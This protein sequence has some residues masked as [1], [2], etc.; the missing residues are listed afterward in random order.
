VLK[1]V[2]VNAED[3]FMDDDY[4]FYAFSKESVP[5]KFKTSRQLNE[6]LAK[7]TDADL[8][9]DTVRPNPFG[10]WGTTIAISCAQMELDRRNFEA[11][12]SLT[13]QSTLISGLIGLVG[14]VV[15]VLLGAWLSS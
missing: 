12:K 7:R 9:I 2:R 15:G 5:Q 14:T 1:I 4:N 8:R 10:D 6:F 11:T 13:R 3:I